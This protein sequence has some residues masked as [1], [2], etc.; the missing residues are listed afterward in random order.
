MLVGKDFW[1]GL[2]EW[3]KEVV[4]QEEHNISQE[5]I[6]LFQVVDTADEA[7]E[8]INAFYDIE[9]FAIAQLEELPDE[10]EEEQYIEIIEG[11]V[12]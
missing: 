6:E 8:V 12:N 3:I 5:D 9:E 10:Q 2:V 7:V 11:E 1:K 4:Q